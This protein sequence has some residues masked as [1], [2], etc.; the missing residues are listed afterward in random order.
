M[1][2]RIDVIAPFAPLCGQFVFAVCG[3]SCGLLSVAAVQDYLNRTCGFLR[4]EALSE[5][6]P[7]KLS[8]SD[9]G[10]LMAVT[11]MRGILDR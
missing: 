4:G 11:L 1:R 5:A 8:E 9:C 3:P 2:K 6:D 7:S 10:D